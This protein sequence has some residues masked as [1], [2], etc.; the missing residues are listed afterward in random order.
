[1]KK[2]ILITLLMLVSSLESMQW[3]WRV[4]TDSIHN[5]ARA[6]IVRD[7]EWYLKQGAT[8]ND[9][10]ASLMRPIHHAALSGNVETVL[11][12][13]KNGAWV[14]D[15][16]ASWRPIHYASEEGH[17]DVVKK[18]IEHGASPHDVTGAE[19]VAPNQRRLVAFDELRKSLRLGPW[20]RECSLRGWNPLHLA[21]RGRDNF[22]LIKF[23]LT[24]R[25]GV[26]D[27]TLALGWQP[28][29]LAAL[30]GNIELVRFLVNHGALLNAT[31]VA[32]CN[33]MHFAAMG[34]NIELM[35]RV[36]L[37]GISLD[38]EDSSGYR[39]IHYAIPRILQDRNLSFITD[40]LE[41][42]ISIADDKEGMSLMH[43]AF[44]ADAP[45]TADLL[46]QWFCSYNKANNEGVLPLHVAARH[47]SLRVFEWL[48]E[49]LD[50]DER[51]RYFDQRDSHGFSAMHYAARESQE[52]I[53]AYLE[54]HNQSLEV[55]NAHGLTP[56]HEAAIHNQTDGVLWLLDHNVS[57]IPTNTEGQT[58]LHVAAACGQTET[59]AM[60]ARTGG[61]DYLLMRDNSNQTALGV[62]AASNH[63]KTVQHLLSLWPCSESQI[64]QAVSLDD[65]ELL[66]ALLEEGDSVNQHNIEGHLPIHIALRDKKRR[67]LEMMLFVNPEL[68]GAFNEQGLTPM[69]VVVGQNNIEAIELGRM[70]GM[71]LSAEAQDGSHPIHHAVREKQIQAIEYLLLHGISVEEVDRENRTALHYA[72]HYDRPSISEETYV[73]VPPQVT[74]YLLDHRA[75]QSSKSEIHG[76]PLMV[77]LR[78]HNWP[79]ARLLIGG[80]L[81]YRV[82][83]VGGNT[84]LAQALLQNAPEDIIKLLLTLAEF[85]EWIN[86]PN[87]NG[88]SNLLIALQS[89]D[90]YYAVALLYVGADE[91]NLD[92]NN[93]SLMSYLTYS[94]NG[95]LQ[96][97]DDIWRLYWVLERRLGP[98]SLGSNSSAAGPSSSRGMTGL[99]KL[100]WI[101]N[102]LRELIEQNRTQCTICLEA[103]NGQDAQ[104]LYVCGHVVHREECAEMCRR[105]AENGALAW[106]QRTIH[107]QRR[108]NTR[109]EELHRIE[110]SSP[111]VRL[112]WAANDRRL[113]EE[114]A[115]QLHES[116]LEANRSGDSATANLLQ[117]FMQ[118]ANR[119]L[120]SSQTV[121]FVCPTCKSR[122]ISKGD[123]I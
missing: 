63:I 80:G 68:R 101:R 35:K 117:G 56:L 41:K 96:R 93:L 105:G 115:G 90:F 71:S 25:V 112:L 59:A 91:T 113:L 67:A 95:S 72:A 11:L 9:T 19:S 16:A 114:Q 14:N 73:A 42:G 89:K 109:L 8:V 50:L 64:F 106:L 83:D 88:S 70:V 27:G 119:R 121:G 5:A 97:I 1:M 99:Q 31:D 120:Q 28:I 47:G 40:L 76:T 7:V 77:A 36:A 22:A 78:A 44:A 81:D 61:L 123:M 75:N 13:L 34:G 110:T 38:V 52:R 66:C 108:N 118:E 20:W 74:K 82:K 30:T 10:D 15:T 32:G 49:Q 6:G 3:A 53:M 4:K 86:E 18:L 69:H 85:S 87:E 116:A 26:S 103:I 60:L 29:H 84:L 104:C 37:H 51:A 46:A 65:G 98:I 57:I 79:V 45:N 92:G 23:L 122:M 33:T 17:L 39:P 102:Q 24:Q 107:E 55:T 2:I 111:E 48:N 58:P 100:H 54:E 43:H 94:I 21:A 62:A 12:L